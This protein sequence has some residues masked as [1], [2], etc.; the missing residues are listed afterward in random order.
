MRRM[1]DTHDTFLIT[2][3]PGRRFDGELSLESTANLRRKRI[4]DEAR[5][6]GH[7]FMESHGGS[8]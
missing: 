8:D 6:K 5:Q 2:R 4:D 3:W 7:T 1:F